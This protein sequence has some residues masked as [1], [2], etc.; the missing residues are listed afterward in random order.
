MTDLALLVGQGGD[1]EFLS[2][3]LLM[4][5]GACD[6]VVREMLAGDAG[7]GE[8]QQ[9]L[10]F[11]LS[12]GVLGNLLRCVRGKCEF[13]ALAADGVVAGKA[14]FTIVDGTMVGGFSV[15]R[16]ERVGC[17]FLITMAAEALRLHERVVCG[18][19]AGIEAGHGIDAITCVG[20]KCSNEP[21]DSGGGEGNGEDSALR[22]EGS[23][24]AAF[25]DG[26]AARSIGAGA[27]RARFAAIRIGAG[28]EPAV[29]LFSWEALTGYA[30]LEDGA[31][32]A[33]SL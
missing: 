21:D 16:D 8:H 32:L 2:V 4:A 33:V 10:G 17:H 22:A 19:V 1:V 12:G 5:V 18:K 29:S 20:G 15:Q 9:F 3:V 6:A 14:E 26:F 11:S 23:F 27:F 31:R 24:W 13:T 30:A 7:C 28:T 25:R